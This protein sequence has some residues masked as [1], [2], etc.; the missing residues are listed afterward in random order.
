MPL[1]FR[2][3]A[4]PSLGA[5][6]NGVNQTCV[7]D[8]RLDTSLNERSFLRLGSFNTC[9]RAGLTIDLINSATVT[10]GCL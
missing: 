6:S 7:I 5:S 9:S 3:V 2:R 8:L 1:M 10:P 4:K